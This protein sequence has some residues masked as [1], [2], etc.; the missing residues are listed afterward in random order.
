[1]ETENKPKTK[2]PIMA[3]LAIALFAF[4]AFVP[5]GNA[6]LL[7]YL[8]N[9]LT[10]LFTVHSPISNAWN[11]SASTGIDNSTVVGN[12]ISGDI[13]SGAPVSLAGTIDNTGT[14]SS[15]NLSFAFSSVYANLSSNNLTSADIPITSLSVDG[16]PAIMPC[17]VVGVDYICTASSVLILTG[18][19]TF[20]FGY[21]TSPFFDS[22]ASLAV[23]MKVV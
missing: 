12:S 4:A 22:T 15:R 18:H 19:H 10:G 5:I 8:G 13:I 11:V 14:P 20:A 6:T 16:S 9:M 2:L 23:A 1:M 3:I 21:T 17:S 7:T